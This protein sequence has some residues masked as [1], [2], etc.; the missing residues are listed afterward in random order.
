MKTKKELNALKKKIETVSK[1]L[2]ELTEEE[3][4]QVTGGT[5]LP[6]VELNNYKMTRDNSTSWHEIGDHE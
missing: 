2:R 5:N 1:D 4:E 6:I 3:L